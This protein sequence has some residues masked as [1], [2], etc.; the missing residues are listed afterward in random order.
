MTTTPACGVKHLNYGEKKKAAKQ[1][2]TKT[3]F[4]SI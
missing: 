4:N 1:K 3:K 2:E